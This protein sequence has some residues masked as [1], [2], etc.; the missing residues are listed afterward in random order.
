MSKNVSISSDWLKWP[1]E[2]L[3][4]VPPGEAERLSSASW[5]TLER[6]YPDYVVHVGRR[7]KGMRVG[8]CLMLSVK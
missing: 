6:N 2:W 8:H 7:R 5:D 3:R 1:I 4:I